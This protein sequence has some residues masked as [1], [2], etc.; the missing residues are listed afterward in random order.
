MYYNYKKEPQN[1]VGNYQG[2][3]VR[4][5]GFRGSGF[6]VQKVLKA[7]IKDTKGVI[8][9]SVQGFSYGFMIGFE[10]RVL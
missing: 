7:F 2:P 5:L 8:C 4:E 9:R 6:R 10:R 1:N 3:Y